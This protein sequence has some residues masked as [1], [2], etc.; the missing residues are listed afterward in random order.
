MTRKKFELKSGNSPSFKMMGLSP[1][2]DKKLR[3]ESTKKDS[4]ADM[5]WGKIGKAA[6]G[7]VGLFL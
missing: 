4:P 6:L 1:S 7:P 2:K 5:N 3:E